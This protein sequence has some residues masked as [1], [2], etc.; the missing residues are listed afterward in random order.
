[1][2]RRVRRRQRSKLDFIGSW[3]RILNHTDPTLVGKEGLVIED[4]ENAFMIGSNS[5]KIL[6]IKQN[7]LFQI[8]TKGKIFV[9]PGTKLIGKPEK[10]G[11][12]FG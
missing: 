9:V 2:A 6:V 3:V 4:T 7:G 11:Y 8:S 5:R 12:K 10:R 1:M